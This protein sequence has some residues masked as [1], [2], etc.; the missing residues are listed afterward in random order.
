M[1]TIIEHD[2]KKLVS[3]LEVYKNVTYN[4]RHYARWA[5]T[6]ILGYA[7]KNIDY[8]DITDEN[9]QKAL[10]THTHSLPNKSILFRNNCDIAPSFFLTLDLA[11]S[12]CFIAKTENA[13]KLKLFLQIH[14]NT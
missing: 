14:K 3:S 8:F 5:R 6:H 9:H 1:I 11:I 4:K 2:G 13:K 10:F 7:K 12:L